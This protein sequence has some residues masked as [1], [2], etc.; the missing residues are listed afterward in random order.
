MRWTDWP[1]RVAQLCS[2]PWTKIINCNIIS[3]FEWIAFQVANLTHFYSNFRNFM[4][5]FAQFINSSHCD[6]ANYLRSVVIDG[7]VT[8]ALPTV[9]NHTDIWNN[10]DCSNYLHQW[11]Y[12]LVHKIWI[13]QRCILYFDYD[14]CVSWWASD[15]SPIKPGLYAHRQPCSCCHLG[16]NI[17]EFECTHVGHFD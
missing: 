9:I 6:Y 11:S 16:V 3:C 5:K 8:D 1:F 12:C 17:D 7:C 10:F 2:S 13:I 14:V 15:C 4:N